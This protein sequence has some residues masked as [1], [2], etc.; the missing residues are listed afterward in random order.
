MNIKTLFILISL[1]GILTPY[2]TPPLPTQ[3]SSHMAVFS[4]KMF[5]PPRSQRSTSAPPPSSGGNTPSRSSRQDQMAELRMQMMHMQSKKKEL[6]L[7][8]VNCP[9]ETLKNRFKA[10]LL[11]VVLCEL[12]C[13]K[14]DH[15][16]S[17]RLVHYEE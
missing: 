2:L 10:E 13:D 6:E 16:K 15:F 14:S 4:K 17:L 7:N 9:N 5:N 8:I 3:K 11:S 1:S 12:F